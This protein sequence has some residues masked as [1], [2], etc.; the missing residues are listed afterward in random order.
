MSARR[1][2]SGAGANRAVTDS[3]A[4][5]P[6][7]YTFATAPLRLGS[8]LVMLH[9]CVCPAWAEGRYVTPRCLPRFAGTVG[10]VTPPRLPRLV[11]VSGRYVT[12]SHLPR[13]GVSDSANKL[14]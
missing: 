13:F 4:S 10:Y 2:R 12:L 3:V 5:L 6:F 11:G 14:R 9:F 1:Q 7:C 8:H